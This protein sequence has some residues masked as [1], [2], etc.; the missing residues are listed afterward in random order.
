MDIHPD[1]TMIKK[2]KYTFPYTCYTMSSQEK[3]CFF[4]L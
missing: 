3:I 1:T 2:G 4:F